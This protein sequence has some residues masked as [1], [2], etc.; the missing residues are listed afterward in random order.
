MLKKRC[1]FALSFDMKE[2]V[3]LPHILN[4]NIDA[5]KGESAEIKY[6]LNL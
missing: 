1:N 5:E 2:R 3:F 6:K 4:K